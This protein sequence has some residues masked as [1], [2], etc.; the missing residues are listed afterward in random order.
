MSKLSKYSPSKQAT[1][2]VSVLAM[3]VCLGCAGETPAKTANAKPAGSSSAS[4]T[5]AKSQNTK[6]KM[7]VDLPQITAAKTL[8]MDDCS[9]I[10]FMADDAA[11]TKSRTGELNALGII[12]IAAAKT[13]L[14]LIATLPDSHDNQFIKPL[15]EIVPKI[16]ECFSLYEKAIAAGKPFS[17]GSEAGPKMA[18]LASEYS[19]QLS[20]AID[21]SLKLTEQK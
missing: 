10:S 13:G 4:E 20:V 9:Q 21:E 3:A 8:M 19:L 16:Q 5:V 15:S 17:D 14:E 18:K 12:D 7:L 1:L 11:F 2:I 6:P